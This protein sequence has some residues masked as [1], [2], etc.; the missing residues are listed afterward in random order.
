MVVV[1]LL[2][3]DVSCDGVCVGHWFGSSHGTSFDHGKY[4]LNGICGCFVP[5]GCDRGTFRLRQSNGRNWRS[6]TLVQHELEES[7][8]QFV[9]DLSRKTRCNFEKKDAAVLGIACCKHIRLERMV[10]LAEDRGDSLQALRHQELA[11]P[12]VAAD[13]GNSRRDRPKPAANEFAT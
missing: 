8:A 13:R 10:A 5:S 11:T 1:V 2:V 4:E 9:S 12:V 3:V 6:P 7:D